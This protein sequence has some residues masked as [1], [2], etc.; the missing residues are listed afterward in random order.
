MNA[1]QLQ[2]VMI[3][4]LAAALLVQHSYLRWR[5]RLLDRLLAIHA[6]HLGHHDASLDSV[7][8]SIDLHDHELGRHAVM[9]NRLD[10][11]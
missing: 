11:R 10:P 1:D 3:A 9:I 6:E 4:V 8:R 2:Y 7:S 5:Q